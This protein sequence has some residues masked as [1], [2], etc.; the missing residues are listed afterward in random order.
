MCKVRKTVLLITS[1]PH[2]YLS[3]GLWSCAYVYM[4]TCV[5][6]IADSLVKT[7]LSDT[8]PWCRLTF[9]QTN[10]GLLALGSSTLYVVVKLVSLLSYR[11]LL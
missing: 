4:C 9:K 2:F 3:L 5:G 6:K 7:S 11:S 1:S 8:L 10:Q